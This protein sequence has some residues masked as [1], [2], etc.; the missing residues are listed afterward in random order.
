MGRVAGI[1]PFQKSLSWKPG[2]LLSRGIGRD[3][4]SASPSLSELPPPLVLGIFWANA[5]V[6]IVASRSRAMPIQAAAG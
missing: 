4:N 2:R 1:F 6:H 5:A 3:R